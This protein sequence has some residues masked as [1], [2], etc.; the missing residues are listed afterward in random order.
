MTQLTLNLEP[1]ITVRNRSLKECVAAGVYTRGVVAV[2]GKIDCSPS[3]LSEALSGGTRKLDVDDLERYI[4][5]TGDLSPI[6]Y[7]VSKF[8]RDPAAQQQEA[9]AVLAKLA[10]TLPG[11]LSAA[12]LAPVAPKSRR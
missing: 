10:E 9:L 7:L 11:L 8:L 1:G 2:A 4:E 5:V 3:H 6:H 12:G